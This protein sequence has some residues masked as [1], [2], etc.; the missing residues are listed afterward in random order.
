L[1]PPKNPTINDVTIAG[2]PEEENKSVET[3]EQESFDALN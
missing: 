3:E 2:P 1:I